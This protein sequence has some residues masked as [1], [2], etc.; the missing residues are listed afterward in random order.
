MNPEYHKNCRGCP[1]LLC[2]FRD[3]EKTMCCYTGKDPKECVCTTCLLRSVCFDVCDQYRNQMR[4]DIGIA[5]IN[6]VRHTRIEV[7]L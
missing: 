6:F 3:D 1:E 7:L 2:F 4:S 5:H